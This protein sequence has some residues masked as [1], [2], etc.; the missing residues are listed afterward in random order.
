M[1][2]VPNPAPAQAGTPRPR[3]AGAPGPRAP[4]NGRAVLAWRGEQA[5]APVLR[6]RPNL[7]AAGLTIDGIVPLPGQYPLPSFGFRYW[8]AAETLA[9]ATSV[10]QDANEAP[11]HWHGGGALAIRLATGPLPQAA[12]TRGDLCFVAAAPGLAEGPALLCHALGH[13]VL[14]ALRPDLWD[15]ASQEVAAF[16]DIFADLTA[17]FAALALPEW[18]AEVIAAGP[19]RI[20][21]LLHPQGAAPT[22]ST[23]ALAML[24]MLAALVRNEAAMRGRTADA[25]LLGAARKAARLLATAVRRVPVVPN[26]LAQI[27]AELAIAAWVQEGPAFGMHLRALFSDRHVLAPTAATATY[28]PHEAE[29]GT[30]IAPDHRQSLPIVAI[31]AAAFGLR[32][33]LL[34]QPASQSPRLA[35][36]ALA[37]NGTPRDPIHPTVA[38]CHFAAELIRTGRAAPPAPLHRPRPQAPGTTHRLVDNGRTLLLQRTRF[39]CTAQ[40]VSVHPASRSI[41]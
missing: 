27:A 10:W 30:E 35:V 21:A 23:F 19:G 3:R 36:A 39:I 41:G 2:K 32:Q 7:A 20:A 37:E 28:D 1:R 18:R 12:Y 9:R 16:H 40:A 6:P 33:P 17:V 22:A 29:D 15:A 25:A 26:F 31:D 4:G 8:N 5:G 13:A 24:D 38:A 11:W 14:D 34:L